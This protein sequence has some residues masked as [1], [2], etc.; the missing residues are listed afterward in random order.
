[1]T[2][3]SMTGKTILITGATNGIDL[4]TALE[5][6]RKG[7]SIAITARNLSKGEATLA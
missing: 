1:M 4:E 3:K 7:A 5:L 2:D 6:A